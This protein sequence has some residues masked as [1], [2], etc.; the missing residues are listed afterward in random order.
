MHNELYSKIHSFVSRRV[1]NKEDVAD[2]VQGIFL[3]LQQKEYQIE[4]R[5][6]IVPWLYRVAR[7][8]IIDHYRKKAVIPP[9]MIEEVQDEQEDIFKEVA[10]WI[11]FFILAMNEQDQRILILTEIE[12]KTQREAA[13]I[14][15]ISLEAAK[16]R[17][18]RAK[19]R[20]RAD[21]EKCCKYSFDARGR[22]MDYE[23]RNEGD[24]CD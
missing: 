22:V 18:Q 19:R 20:L 1:S 16:A 4:D 11:S 21:M 8:H 5:E 7:N 6:L 13:K 3:K 2:L 9:D 15:D 12:G 23:I 17:H 24:C 14:L 10:S